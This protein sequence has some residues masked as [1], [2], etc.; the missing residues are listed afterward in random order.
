MYFQFADGYITKYNVDASK[1]GNKQVDVVSENALDIYLRTYCNAHPL[2][3]FSFAVGN[4]IEE[5]VSP[6][7]AGSLK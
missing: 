6:T 2:Q 1:R 3:S 7:A 5:S 4:F